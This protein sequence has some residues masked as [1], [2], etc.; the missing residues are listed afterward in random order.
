MIEP[1]GLAAAV[2]QA[3]DAIV[4]TSTRGAIL[5]VNPAFTAMTGYTSA[6]AVGQ[7]TR[8]LKSG[9][10]AHE[11]Y[12]ELWATVAAGKVWQGEIVNRRKDGTHYHEEMKIAPVQD[13]AGEIIHY[14]AIKRDITQQKAA[15]ETQRLL[16]AIVENSE[17]AILSCAADGAILSWNHGAEELFGYS[18]AEAIGMWVGKLLPPD[19]H[20]KMAERIA[21][22]LRSGARRYPQTESLD[23]NGQTQQVS[24]VASPIL[25]S[26]GQA[27]A[28]SVIVRNLS[29]RREAE[30]TRGL[31]ASLVESSDDAMMGMKLDGTIVSWNR[32]ARLLFGYSSPE[33]LGRTI[34]ILCAPERAGEMQR[35]L[36]VVRNGCSISPFVTVL[37]AMD[38]TMVDVSLAISPIRN[39]EGEVIGASCVVREIGETLRFERRLRESEDRFRGVFEHA[40]VGM[41][42]SG[43]DG[44]L[45]QVNEAFCRMLG[46]AREELIATHWKD[47]THPEDILQSKKTLERLED[48]SSDSVELEERYLHRDGHPVWVRLRMS[49]VRGDGSTYF[50]VHVEDITERRRAAGILRESQ[51]LFRSMAD[52]CPAMMWC[53]SAEGG[54]EFINRAYAEFSGHSAESVDA[55]DWRTLLHPDDAP[56]YLE[57]FERAVRDRRPFEAE[58]R[59]LRADGEWRWVASYARPRFGPGRRVSGIRGDQSRHHRT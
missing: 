17:D 57:A 45:L 5:Y 1:I 35:C 41:L 37:R 22:V 26:A 10:H 4:I 38:H 47:L 49:R 8:I 27:V 24:A 28:L 48:G 16:A 43:A 23:K 13:A 3:A 36:W 56:Q 25:D 40:P 21:E 52:S 31:L 2:E 51:E 18:A 50:V 6:E 53:C 44:R 59:I 15:A 54:A 42:V 32:G 33:V 12:R 29:A 34:E 39:P 58:V 9:R 30:Q 14:I 55:L 46:Y 11:F 20:A 19:R 7:H